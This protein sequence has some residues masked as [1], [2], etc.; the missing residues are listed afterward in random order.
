M[1]QGTILKWLVGPG[2]HVSRGDI[3]A[4]VQ[5]EKSDI[6][7]EIWQSGTI[8]EVLVDTGVQVPVGTP[9]LR[10]SGAEPTPSGTP[11]AVSETG[12]SDAPSL[13]PTPIGEPSV[14]PLPIG[15]PT[16]RSRPLSSPLARALC[17][18]RGVN[19]AGLT[20]SGPGGAVIARDVPTSSDSQAS[21]APTTPT[22]AQRMRNAIAERMSIANRDIPHYHLELE[23]DMTAALAWLA[24]HND[25]LEVGQRVLPAA[26][27]IKATAMAAAEVPALNGYWEGGTFNAANHV[28]VAVAV[29]LRRGG[30]VTPVI[31]SGDELSIDQTMN[32]LRDRVAGARSGSLRSSWMEGGTITITN[33]GDNGADRVF[34]V[35]FPPQVALIGFGRIRHQPVIVEDAVVSRPVVAA[36]LSADHR[37]TDG[38][39]GSRFLTRLNHH[40]QNPE[41]L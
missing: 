6:D 14:L 3:V 20:G 10:L 37:A 41:K 28:N 39:T 5:T 15:E 38:A 7:V 27:L 35:I 16:T 1:D 21:A 17:E 24:E 18:D 12:P 25:P 30:L 13:A 31:A 19:I 32:A 34:G 2:D 33:L 23:I 4:R 29:S 11:K 9:L 40:L 36:T 22:A 8:D 26:L